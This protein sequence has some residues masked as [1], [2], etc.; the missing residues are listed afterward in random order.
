VAA[1]AV[2]A[3]NASSPNDSADDGPVSP[4]SKKK[5][6]RNRGAGKNK[7]KAKVDAVPDTVPPAQTSKVGREPAWDA[8]IMAILHEYLAEYLDNRL[9]GKNTNALNGEV[10]ARITDRLGPMCGFNVANLMA[11][12]PGPVLGTTIRNNVLP[13]EHIPLCKV[14]AKDYEWT[15]TSRDKFRRDCRK[16]RSRCSLDE[17]FL[18]TTMYRWSGSAWALF[19][20]CPTPPTSTIEPTRYSSSSS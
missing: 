1:T 12:I 6:K 18:M 2:P 13:M 20:G 4:K 8:H 19:C 11:K 15:V 16:V 5:Q 7:K 14:P 10:N 9:P 17:R 3:S